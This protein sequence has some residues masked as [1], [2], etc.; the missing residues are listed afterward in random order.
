MPDRQMTTGHSSLC[1]LQG[2][3]WRGSGSRACPA[4][5]Y[6][7]PVQSFCLPDP[8]L[9]KIVPESQKLRTYLLFRTRKRETD[10]TRSSPPRAIQGGIPLI[11]IFCRAPPKPELRKVCDTFAEGVILLG[12]PSACNPSQRAVWGTLTAEGITL[13]NTPSAK[14]IGSEL[15]AS[16]RSTKGRGLV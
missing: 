7:L 8:I 11:N 12:I 16:D 4:A 1:G 10:F 14:L 2:G 6:G 9:V 3:R 5:P 15:P 13:K